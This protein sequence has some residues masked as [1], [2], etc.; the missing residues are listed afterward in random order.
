MDWFS[1]D[2]LSD[3]VF[4]LLEFNTYLCEDLKKLHALENLLSFEIT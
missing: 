2:L 1:C 4:D 3:I